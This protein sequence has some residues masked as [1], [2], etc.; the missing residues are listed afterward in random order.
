MPSKANV[1]WR[2]LGA[3][4]MEENLSNPEVNRQ[5]THSRHINPSA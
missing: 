2:A 3:E 4:E 5:Q 1:D